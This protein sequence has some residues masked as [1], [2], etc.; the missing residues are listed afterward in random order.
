MSFSYSLLGDWHRVGSLIEDGPPIKGFSSLNAEERVI[1]LSDGS[2]TLLLEALLS[3]RV[4]V[5]V[6]R[7]STQGLSPESA[8]YLDEEPGK[9]SVER[10][11]WLKVKGERLV[12][13][14]LVV[15]V[16]SIEPWLLRAL[17]EG[18]EP[19]G[20]VLQARE[21]PV[22]KEALE[23]GV[24]RA[25]EVSQDLRVDPDT[26][27]YARRYKLTNRVEGGGWIIKAEICEVLSPALVNPL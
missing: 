7:N 19:L 6:K 23:I 21:I 25:P 26:L 24:V 13:A 1:L 9:E 2:L 17:R 22:L 18:E 5:E 27:L 4:S 12:F 11:V 16:C 3:D 10:E 20:R 8:L 15:P 14:H